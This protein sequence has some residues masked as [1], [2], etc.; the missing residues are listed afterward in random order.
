M[1][2]DDNND[3]DNAAPVDDSEFRDELSSSGF[4]PNADSMQWMLAKPKIL[5][6]GAFKVIRTAAEKAR[7]IGGRDR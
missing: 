4:K 5:V 1:L 6:A 3:D 7:D 2:G